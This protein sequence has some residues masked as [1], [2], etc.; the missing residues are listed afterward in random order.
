MPPRAFENF[1]RITLHPKFDF[2]NSSQTFYHSVLR[3]LH[4]SSSPTKLPGS[5]R[6]CWSQS[7]RR[8]GGCEE[9][10]G[11]RQAQI[12]LWPGAEQRRRS[13]HVKC[14]RFRQLILDRVI[15]SLK[16]PTLRMLLLQPGC[17]PRRCGDRGGAAAA[18]KS[19]ADAHSSSAYLSCTCLT[20]K[21]FDIYS[22][23]IR[24]N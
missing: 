3:C 11:G 5:W 16:P 6:S 19:N 9:C 12:L 23:D 7:R 17:T 24:P 2:T 13:R 20:C 21:A 22:Y 8:R 4:G 10:G 15:L 1:S 14:S 18:S